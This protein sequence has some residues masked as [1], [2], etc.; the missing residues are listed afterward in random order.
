MGVW[1]ALMSQSTVSVVALLTMLLASIGGP[2]MTVI[3]MG[4]AQIMS[5]GDM[6]GRIVGL[7]IMVGFGIQPIAS[8]W[9]G[10][11]AEWLGIPFAIL[12]NGLCLVAGAVLIILTRRALFKWEVPSS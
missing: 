9:I 4:L 1:F 10:Y 5:P 2:A 7:F 8:L 6:R 11:L 12:L 3:A